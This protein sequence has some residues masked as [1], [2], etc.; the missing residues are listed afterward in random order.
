[1]QRPDFDREIVVLGGGPAGLAAAWG[2]EELERPYRV[3]EAAPTHGGNARTIRFGQFLYDTGPHRFHD[4]DPAA[5]RRVLE[6]LG[7]DMQTVDAPSRIYWNGRFVDFPLR[8]LQALTSGSISRAARAIV[9]LLA[10]RLTSANPANVED[11]DSWAR[12]RFGRTVA[13]SF[14]IPFSEKLWG[15]PAAELS[16]DIA[17]RRLPGFRLLSLLKEAVLRESRR[18]HL[19][20]RFLYP[21][22]G[23]GQIVDAVAQQLAPGRLQCDCRVTRVRTAGGKISGVECR[24]KEGVETFQAD[25]VVNTLPITLLVRMMEPAPPADVL[26][27][28]A[29]L[30]FRDVLLVALFLDQESVS[31]AACTYFS[32]ARV[33]FSR[34]H[35]PRNRS[36]LM[37]PPGKTSLVVEFPCFEGNPIWTRHEATVVD[38]LIRELARIGLIE[39][40][41]VEASHVTRLHKAYPVYSKDYGKLSRIVL[42]YLSTFENLQTI[43]RGGSFFYGHVHDFVSAGFAAARAIDSYLDTMEIAVPYPAATAGARSIAG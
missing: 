22:H 20:G 30:R 41:K 3:L 24:S 14:L 21:R 18:D 9:D 5:T 25:A 43:G 2:L 40:G 7:N 37:S 38:D 8:P 39:P 1:M 36:R 28:A 19:E 32:D 11:F 17:G 10:A 12:L 4:R 34:A 42:S 13:E 23:Y 27:A 33:P 16:P 31:D 15:L 29:R 35:E 26:A 6:L